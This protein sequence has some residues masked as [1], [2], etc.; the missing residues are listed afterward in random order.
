MHPR[1]GIILPPM[2]YDDLLM[3]LLYYSRASDGKEVMSD[4]MGPRTSLS[5]GS[6]APSAP[7]AGDRDNR[8]GRLGCGCGRAPCL[9]VAALS[10][11][12]CTLQSVAPAAAIEA[13]GTR[14]TH[15]LSRSKAVEG[16]RQHLLH[17][18]ILLASIFEQL[19]R[20]HSYFCPSRAHVVTCSRSGRHQSTVPLPALP[21]SHLKVLPGNMTSTLPQ[22]L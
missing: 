2:I 4:E 15:H 22:S 6:T 8:D 12:H 17:S 18:G 19:S 7:S 13:R 11:E 1:N 16:P 3:P 21:T 10:L 14:G 20:C 5:D 9:A